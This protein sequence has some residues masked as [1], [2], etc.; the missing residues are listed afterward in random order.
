MMN[1]SSIMRDYC[2]SDTNYYRYFTLDTG[3][4]RHKLIMLKQGLSDI[5]SLSELV[6]SQKEAENKRIMHGCQSLS[7]GII[8]HVDS[9]LKST[10]ELL[11]ADMHKGFTSLSTDISMSQKSLLFVRS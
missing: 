2:R 9:E 3:Y 11:E 1:K 5:A 8:M 4:A 10:I 6:L 7:I